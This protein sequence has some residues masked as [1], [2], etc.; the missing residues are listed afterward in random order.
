MLISSALSFAE[1][2]DLKNGTVFLNFPNDWQAHKDLFGLPLSILGPMKNESR[3][4]ISVTTT[5]LKNVEFAKDFSKAQAGYKEG[6]IKFMKKHKGRALKFYDYAMNKNES[7]E[8]HQFGYE[9]EV[10]GKSF[11][12]K[13]FYVKCNKQLFHLKTLNQLGKSKEDKQLEKIVES[14]KCL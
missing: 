4:M 5:P 6:R 8:I 10:A 13:T 3:P 2:F 11:K 1:A 9:Y 14:F 7:L 12:E